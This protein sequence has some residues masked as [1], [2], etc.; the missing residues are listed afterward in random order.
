MQW[1]ERLWKVIDIDRLVW[2]DE[3]NKAEKLV[4]WYIK[5]KFLIRD[6]D[7]V[8]DLYCHTLVKTKEGFESWKNKIKDKTMQKPD[9]AFAN[10]AAWIVRRRFAVITTETNKLKHK[11]DV[12]CE[13]IESVYRNANISGYKY[14]H[15]YGRSILYTDTP[16]EAETR[17]Y[18]SQLWNKIDISEK[19]IV[20][21][22]CNGW[23]LKEIAKNL[24]IS[25]QRLWQYLEPMRLRL[26]EAEDSEIVVSSVLTRKI[27]EFVPD[28]YL[29]QLET[30][31]DIEPCWSP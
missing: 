6:E 20:N 4:M 14:S 28:D 18:I 12:L 19:L 3:W 24:G 1:Y 26:S 31:W 29:K 11:N 13:C 7:L 8:R 17:I 27:K 16:N 23:T 5:K 21:L 2:E 15:G 22:V 30:R 10:W 9:K 25:R